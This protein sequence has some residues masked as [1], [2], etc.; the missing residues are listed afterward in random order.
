MVCCA[1]CP[2]TNT[3]GAGEAQPCR[4]VV[5]NGVGVAAAARGGAG[6]RGRGKDRSLVANGNM[7]ALILPS[8]SD[9]AAVA[10]FPAMRLFQGVPAADLL[11]T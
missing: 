6:A 8:E 2:S 11:E 5:V 9:D 7:A 4:C 1:C 3:K 10:C